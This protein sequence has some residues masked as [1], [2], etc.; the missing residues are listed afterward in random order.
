MKDK[1]ID[2]VRRIDDYLSPQTSIEDGHSH[3]FKI[4]VKGDSIT[5]ATIPAEH[6]D[7]RHLIIDFL[8]LPAGE[9]FHIHQL[10]GG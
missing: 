4:N 5:T 9:Y 2:I 8:V 7:H 3:S 6:K 10:P 1:N